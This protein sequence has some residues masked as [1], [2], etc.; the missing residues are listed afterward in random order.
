MKIVTVSVKYRSIRIGF[1]VQNGNKGD[2]RKAVKN[3]TILW[4]GRFNPIIPIGVDN[5]YAQQLV[6]LF[7]PD[8]LY[9]VGSSKEVDE[10]IERYPFLN[11]YLSRTIFNAERQGSPDYTNLADLQ[12]PLKALRNEDKEKKKDLPTYAIPSWLADDPMS[13]AFLV[14]FGDFPK[15]KTAGIDYRSLFAAST[16]AKQI[17]ID[18]K[19]SIP[20]LLHKA[21]YPKRVSAGLFETSENQFAFNDGIFVGNAN[22]FDDL[23]NFWNISATGAHL[24]FF[25]P[26]AKARWEQLRQEEFKFL[27]NLRPMLPSAGFKINIWTNDANFA[28]PKTWGK[29]VLRRSCDPEHT[30]NGLNLKPIFPHTKGESTLGHFSSERAGVEAAI[31]LAWTGLKQ[32]NSGLTKYAVV[33]V[34]LSS[35][36]VDSADHTLQALPLPEINSCYS[37]KMVWLRDSI[38]LGRQGLGIIE[39]VGTSTLDLRSV[40]TDDIITEIFRAFGIF[41]RVSN[42]GR[43]CRRMIIQLGGL[44]GC[45]LLK[46]PG[47]RRLIAEHKPTQSFSKNKAIEYIRSEFGRFAEMR[48]LPRQ[49]GQCTPNDVFTAILRRKII[50]LGIEVL[51]SDCQLENWVPL[52]NFGSKVD[53]EYCGSSI[54]ITIEI[55]KGMFAYRRSGIFGKDDN[56]KGGIPVALVGEFLSQI[57]FPNKGI[58]STAFNLSPQGSKIMECE[59]DFVFI[60]NSE[61]GMSWN[62]GNRLKLAIGECKTNGSIKIG[63]IENLRRV[64]DAFPRDRID[65]YLIFAKT[66]SFSK[67]EVEL[68]YSAQGEREQRVILLS[69]SELEQFWPFTKSRYG[70][71]QSLA[72]FSMISEQIYPN[73]KRMG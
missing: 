14:Q 47:V 16:K 26:K 33:A 52:E 68:C 13:D 7:N 17:Q 65:P 42:A 72:D 29:D 27:R 10:F 54:E 61:R 30:W 59:T 60:Q 22:S 21:L 70:E 24:I 39:S 23:V 63:D 1:C 3:S 71:G 15:K 49:I 31:P 11:W 28:I 4:G 43:V 45:K 37:G 48:I 44:G 5:T 2:L 62:L 12:V 20:K 73:V 66:G 34:D 19:K 40:R 67:E 8:I 57:S 50:R 56:Q 35:S 46:I 51:C 58:F 9:P 25:D 69:G 38:R 41:A 64:A 32:E 55:S 6:K 53:C 18:P 36:G